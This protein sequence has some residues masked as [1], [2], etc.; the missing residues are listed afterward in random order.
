MFDYK[1][2]HCLPRTAPS[3]RCVCV[4]C[5]AESDESHQDCDFSYTDYESF[6]GTGVELDYGDDFEDDSE[7]IDNNLKIS[8][9]VAGN[10]VFEMHVCNDV[11]STK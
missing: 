9:K 4:C 3:K 8:I 11:I 2:D 5:A 6:D 10:H 7:S 1:I